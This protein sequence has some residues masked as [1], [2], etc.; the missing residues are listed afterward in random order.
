[1]NHID[2]TIANNYSLRLIN[3]HRHNEA[4][5]IVYRAKYW[6]QLSVTINLGLLSYLADKNGNLAPPLFLDCK[7]NELIQLLNLY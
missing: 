2:A 6:C 4:C 3:L 5:R 1:M 7:I